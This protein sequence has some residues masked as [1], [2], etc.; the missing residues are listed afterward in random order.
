MNFNYRDTINLLTRTP[1]TL[2]SLLSGLPEGWVKN[3][4]SEDSWNVYEVVGHLIECERYNFIPR[5]KMILIEGEATTFPPFDRYSQL[6]K[7]KNESVEELL[8]LF[9]QLRYE[10]IEILKR[11]INEEIDW[12]KK[13]V[14]PEFGAV[15]LREQLS[16][17]VVHD[18]S[19][20]SQMTRVMANRYYDDVGPWKKYLRVMNS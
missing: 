4:E 19:H 7:Y 16:T 18:L 15:S 13:G 8:E 1:S 10:N 5:V 12:E 17:W 2:K 14:H 20:I 11:L 9:E 6:S 3:R